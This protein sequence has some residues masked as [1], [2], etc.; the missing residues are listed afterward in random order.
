M[1]IKVHSVPLS[2]K[3]FTKQDLE[4]SLKYI[5]TDV[6]PGLYSDDE[7]PKGTKFVG[8]KLMNIN[9]INISLED[10]IDSK[11]DTDKLFMS[12]DPREFGRGID[13]DKVQASIEAYG[14]K[15]SKI[16]MSVS[17]LLDGKDY[18]VNGR[19]RLEKLMKEGFT[20]VIVDYYTS[21]SEDAF[22]RMTVYTNGVEDPS[23]PHT[24]GDIIKHCNHA[25]AMGWIKAEYD[26]IMKRIEE[27]APG[28]FTWQTNNKMALVVCGSQGRTNKVVSLSESKA[29]DW[30]Q[31]YGYID[32]VKNNGIYYKII[33]TSFYSKAITMA[34]KYLMHDLK[35]LHVKELRLV[36]QTDTLD[37]ADPELSWKSKTDTFRNKYESSLRDIE[38][39]YFNKFET[40]TT[41]KLFGVIPAVQSLAHLYPM[42]KL[43]MFHVGKLKDNTFSEI[44]TNDQEEENNLFRLAA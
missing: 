42:D 12:Q 16:P 22:S 11:L 13:A 35:G 21:C 8:R 4:I 17:L 32:N 2:A 20:N 14:F 6:Y 33:S 19:T 43:V 24:K 40:R 26:S 1:S 23:S 37:G 38:Q 34:A 15:L 31:K 29:K 7:L 41:I 3:K 5:S 27:V 44:D 36:L 25:I 28:S 18:I 30:M 39:G 9:D 10:N